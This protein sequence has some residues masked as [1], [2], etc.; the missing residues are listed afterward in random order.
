[1]SGHGPCVPSSIALQRQRPAEAGVRPAETAGLR[2]EPGYGPRPSQARREADHS[3]YP[4]SSC[5]FE[6]GERTWQQRERHPMWAL[7]RTAIPTHCSKALSHPPAACLSAGSAR[8]R[9][10]ICARTST[11]KH[12]DE[13][14]AILHVPP[15]VMCALPEGEGARGRVEPDCVAIEPSGGRQQHPRPEGSEGP[16]EVR[17]VDHKLPG[18]SKASR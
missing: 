3:V 10:C 13:Q 7:A 9:S 1:M 2:A 11:I 17:G 5:R 15:S 6:G 14:T 12:T 8:M 16:G 4:H 18:G